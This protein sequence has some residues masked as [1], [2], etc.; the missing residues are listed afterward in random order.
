MLTNK[1]DDFAGSIAGTAFNTWAGPVRVAVSGEYR[2]FSLNIDSNFLP[3]A[4]VDCSLLNAQTCPG[5]NNSNGPLNPATQ[6]PAVWALNVVSPVFAKEN[7][8]EIAGEVDVPLLRDTF[9]AKAFNLNGA[10][11]YTHYS[12]TGNATTWKV[13][14][15]WD[16][17]DSIKFRGTR[18]RDFRAPTLQ[19][20]FNPIQSGISSYNDVLTSQ[21]V[22]NMI[23]QTQGNRT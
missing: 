18:S 21:S 22:P 3:T 6:T 13:G 16:V 12:I 15:T 5:T 17:N 10:V 20:L 2:D 11:R 4:K 14:F 23:V 9:L 8:A 1:L 7:V 19:D